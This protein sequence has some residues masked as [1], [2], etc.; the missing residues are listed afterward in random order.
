MINWI[1]VEDRLPS[2]KDHPYG[3]HYLCIVHIKWTNNQGETL[4]ANN[5]AWYDDDDE[6][7]RDVN[8]HYVTHWMYAK[9]LPFPD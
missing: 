3:A 6:C 9:D 4:E 8:D 5:T 2:C 7:W 1:S